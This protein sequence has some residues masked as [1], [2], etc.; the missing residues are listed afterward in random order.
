MGS[1]YVV[2]GVEYMMV[3]V[4]AGAV[5]GALLRLGGE[6]FIAGFGFEQAHLLSLFMINALGCYAFAVSECLVT[7]VQKRAFW[8]TGCWGTFTSFSA[9]SGIFLMQEMS[10]T[11]MLL[12]VLACVGSWWLCYVV[13]GATADRFRTFKKALY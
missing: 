7:Q 8:L 4:F 1:V 11:G 13:G 3:Y 9:V 5:V 10:L 2:T 12:W 6:W